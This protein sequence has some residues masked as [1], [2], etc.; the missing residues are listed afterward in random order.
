MKMRIKSILCALAGVVVSLP[1][2]AETYYWGSSDTGTNT[3]GFN[4]E[5]WY[6]NQDATGDP[7]TVDFS[8]GDVIID[9]ANGA[10]NG[11]SPIGYTGEFKLAEWNDT[12]S[13]SGMWHMYAQAS[14]LSI[15]VG[16][17]TKTS[18]GT[19]RIRGASG[20][21]SLSFRIE[22]TLDVSAGK[23][24]IGTQNETSG[25]TNF[26][27]LSMDVG[28]MNSS[29]TA[30]STFAL[31]GN[32]NATTIN[33]NG[34]RVYICNGTESASDPN[35]LQA[36]IGTV[37][38]GNRQ[39]SATMNQLW[40]QADYTI[41][42]EMNIGGSSASGLYNKNSSYFYIDKVN[43]LSGFT[44]AFTFGNSTGT[45]ADATK[46]FEIGY[47]STDASVNAHPGIVYAY[48][49]IYIDTAE[50]VG[51]GG[52]APAASNYNFL[53]QGGSG[54]VE[55][56]NLT[57]SKG[58]TVGY[59]IN[60]V[61]PINNYLGKVTVKDVTVTDGSL[62]W[63]NT[64]SLTQKA[65]GTIT[66]SGN[67][68]SIMAMVGNT[69][70]ESAVDP[71][72]S[73]WQANIQG[74]VIIE[75]GASFRIRRM[76]GAPNY[77]INNVE[78]ISGEYGSSFYAV[79]D[80]RYP[81]GS[82]KIDTI[83]FTNGLENPTGTG[84]AQTFAFAVNSAASASVGTMTMGDYTS[85]NINAY[86]PLTVGS[87]TVGNMSYL[88][89]TSMVGSNSMTVEGDFTNAG[90]RLT[91]NSSMELVVEGDFINT[92]HYQGPST[93][94][95]LDLYNRGSFTVGGA[96][97]NNG[98]VNLGAGS[99]AGT[100]V[101]YSFGGISSS[102]PED[103]SDTSTY[104]I[105]AA[106]SA[107]N[108]N[109]TLTGD[110]TYIYTNR[111]H[112]FGQ[113]TPDL[114]SVTSRINF[115]KNGS[116]T[117]YFASNHIYYL[118]TTTVN[119]GALYICANGTQNTQKRGIGDLILNGGIF[120]A[121]GVATSDTQVDAIGVAKMDNFTWDNSG[122]VA[123]DF[124]GANS[125]L[126]EI[127][128]DFT[129][130]ENSSDGTWGFIF[131]GNMAYNTEYALITW[132]GSTDFKESDFD[133]SSSSGKILDG[134]FI[135]K[136]NTLYYATVIPEPAEYAAIFGFMALALAYMRRRQRR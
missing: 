80:Y 53:I 25:T 126:I 78:L 2:Y 60:L 65:S 66:V 71:D 12:G 110:G 109:I 120:G 9:R 44:G 49:N 64:A 81:S 132:E 73:T 77:F 102:L 69:P 29:G 46:E 26:A 34:G 50:H 99:T 121:C 97:V 125:D 18:A 84:P 124:S 63:F 1:V 10:Y 128:G 123:V 83:T 23:F 136:D 31:S 93:P 134:M 5:T 6:D 30:S 39:N 112:N 45:T 111:I 33:M 4:L 98:L 129:K 61:S 117:Q 51:A 86:N 130:S 37:N 104:R 88:A 105:Y 16:S 103:S 118:G 28:T 11:Q 58:A 14:E 57:V 96:F 94:L 85:T 74:S 55:V 122:N 17:M 131:N 42:E 106:S 75:N 13:G 119:E 87:I 70:S 116:G 108:I 52:A 47:L 35:Y 27:F 41:I 115:V 62:L 7:Q 48:S 135:I 100:D 20:S 79:Q 113:I 133:Y 54:S 32:F 59:G 91:L 92:S 43:V 19:L 76:S 3:G 36:Q 15:V 107:G 68:S 90:S 114:S 40:T 24:Q 127:S 38:F 21:S 22:D 101:N 72:P 82:L 89:L 56:D 67:G 95:G 8:K